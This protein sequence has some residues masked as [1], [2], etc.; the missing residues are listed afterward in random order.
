MIKTNWESCVGCG[1]CAA[2]C[3]T[4]A[5][6]LEK[7]KRGFI[8]PQVCAEACINCGLCERSCPIDNE[9]LEFSS[10]HSVYGA[11]TKDVSVLLESS[12]GGIFSCLADYIVQ[13][14]GIV[15]GAVFNAS[16]EVKHIGSNEPNVICRMR[17]SKY[18]Q[19]DMAGVFESIKSDI[20]AGKKVLFTGTPCQCAAIRAFFTAK[21][22]SQTNLLVVEILCDGVNSPLIWK[23]YLKYITNNGIV[24]NVQ[25]RNKSS[26]WKEKTM[27]IQYEHRDSNNLKPIIHTYSKSYRD[28]FFAQ[29]FGCHYILRQSCY[30]CRFAKEDRIADLTI[31]DF[32]AY[33]RLP[34]EIV[35]ENGVSLVLVNTAK[36]N[37]LF[38]KV[39]E[40]LNY[41]SSDLTTA[42]EKQ[43]SLRAAPFKNS[44]TEAF[45]NCYQAYGFTR[46]IKKYTSCGVFVKTKRMVKRLLVRFLTIGKRK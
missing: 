13:H 29:L 26:G 39:K 46:A 1:C 5:I 12:S 6:L 14:Q 18:L 38:N 24:S 8:V 16:W 2:V 4:H 43:G 11:Y 33:D 25:F 21:N 9:H 22:L 23:D 36:G 41:V 7:D 35:S 19:S 27:V 42:K 3:P 20:L 31:G 44:D 17:G 15:Y 32:W 28:D 45:W 10:P 40:R 37:A 34:N 30:E